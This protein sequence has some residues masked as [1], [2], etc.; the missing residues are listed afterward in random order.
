M[1]AEPI[2]DVDTQLMEYIRDFR[3]PKTNMALTFTNY[4]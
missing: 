2:A 1:E 3:I 4:Y